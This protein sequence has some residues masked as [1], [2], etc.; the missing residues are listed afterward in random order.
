[1]TPFRW[2]AVVVLGALLVLGGGGA[3]WYAVDRTA[4][5]ETVC[6]AGGPNLSRPRAVRDDQLG[7]A[8]LGPRQRI[9]G[10]LQQSFENSTLFI[11]HTTG[12]F[13]E[14]AAWFSPAAGLL[15]HGGAALGEQLDK[16]LG[17]TCGVRMASVTVEGWMTVSEGEFGHLGGWTKEFYADRVIASGPP[18][19]AVVA[20]IRQMAVD[21]GMPADVCAQMDAR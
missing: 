1:M 13:G 19:E 2:T 9:T 11:G 6:K 8:V 10:T 7:C 20:D 5:V 18:P 12:P 14:D 17:G 21:A 16:S 3:V 4:M 15:E